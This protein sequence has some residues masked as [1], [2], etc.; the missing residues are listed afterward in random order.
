MSAAGHTIAGRLGTADACFVCREFSLCGDAL[1]YVHYM[2]VS[3]SVSLTPSVCDCVS[4]C[5]CV[6]MR[7]CVPVCVWFRVHAFLCVCGCVYRLIPL[8]TSNPAGVS[9]DLAIRW[10]QHDQLGSRGVYMTAECPSPVQNHTTARP[11]ANKLRAVR[12]ASQKVR[13][14]CNTDT[15]PAELLQLLQNIAHHRRNQQERLRW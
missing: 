15:V 1:I 8:A 6:C 5:L 12:T 14:N 7:M 4:V 2:R 3:P 10:A 13:I 11:C 9:P